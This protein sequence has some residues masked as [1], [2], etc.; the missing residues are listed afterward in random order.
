MQREVFVD[1]FEHKEGDEDRV[2]EE[3]EPHG[4]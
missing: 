1:D 3:A 2:E 4:P